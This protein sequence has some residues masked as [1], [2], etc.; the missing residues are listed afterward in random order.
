MS[1]KKS[2]RDDGVS[3]TPGC[4]YDGI[5]ARGG[6]PANE[7]HNPTRSTINSSSGDWARA[8]IPAAAIETS[9]IGNTR[10]VCSAPRTI[11]G[12]NM[13]RRNNGF[14]TPPANDQ[15][16]TRKMTAPMLEMAVHHLIAFADLRESVAMLPI[17]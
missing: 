3:Y 11:T 6:F 1:I 10:R 14:F 15:P 5:A 4:E 8:D 13:L 12:T 9:A 2:R 17:R 7:I 16:T